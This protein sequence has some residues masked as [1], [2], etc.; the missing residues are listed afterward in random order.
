M[1]RIVTI[2]LILVFALATFV[3]SALKFQNASADV[4]TLYT[5]DIPNH[6]LILIGPA[7][8][9]YESEMTAFLSGKDAQQQ[10]F[11]EDLK[12]F[13]A[14][15]KNT[16][17]KDVVAY[18]LRWE[19]SGADMKTVTHDR[20]FADPALLMGE[21]PARI[22]PAVL[23]LGS[24]IVSNNSRFVAVAN[25]LSAPIKP[26]ISMG[27]GS[28]IDSESPPSQT[29]DE[30]LLENLR[31]ELDH[32]TEITISIDGAVFSDGTF[33]GPDETGYFSQ[34]KAQ[35]AAKFDLLRGTVIA[36]QQ[37]GTP[38]EIYSHIQTIVDAPA[39]SI[40]PD[41]TDADYYNFYRQIYA[42][43]MLAMRTAHNNDT[44]ALS[45]ALIPL[46]RIWPTLMKVE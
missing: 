33:V 41:S 2:T 4:V 26:S 20:V 30:S 22:T 1:K 25:S 5:R 46:N 32:A 42:Q 44:H 31:T 37:N 13:S 8:S 40:G 36:I 45:Y 17:S 3:L 23:G 35:I 6:G 28:D 21:D 9:S 16:N 29:D 15:L 39:I 14:F 7:S 24:T 19:L 10:A 27:S 34:F 43:E 12:P 38:S 18:K 11:I